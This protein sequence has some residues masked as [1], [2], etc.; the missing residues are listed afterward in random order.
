KPGQEGFIESRRSLMKGVSDYRTTI[1]SMIA[2]GD[3]V[4]VCVT[5]TFTH[6]G[7]FFDIPPTNRKV[8][9]TEMTVWRIVKGKITDRWCTSDSLG[10]LT[11]IGATLTFPKK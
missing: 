8:S 6:T 10:M 9:Y 5:H 3:K 1:D 2:E 7:R 4:A 11:Q